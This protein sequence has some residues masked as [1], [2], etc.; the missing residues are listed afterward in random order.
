MR[1]SCG[2]DMSKRLASNS[3]LPDTTKVETMPFG[4]RIKPSGLECIE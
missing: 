1:T 2:K 3:V 4:V